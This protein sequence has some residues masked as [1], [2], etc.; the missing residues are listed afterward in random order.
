MQSITHNEELIENENY[1]S[2]FFRFIY[3][4]KAPETKRQYP[5]RLE[6]FLDYLKLQGNTIEEKANRFYDYA[7][8]NPKAFQNRLLNYIEHHKKR[9]TLGEI[10]ESTVPNYYK[11][12][13]LFCDMNDII[14]NWKIVTRGIPKGRHASE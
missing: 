4:L 8:E 6:V 12:I 3:A 1:D 9:A 13:K 5:K 7:L 14:I 10:S 2:A 11:P